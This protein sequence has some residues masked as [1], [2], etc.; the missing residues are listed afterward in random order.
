MDHPEC[1]TAAHLTLWHASAD[2]ASETAWG[3][4]LGS[5]QAEAAP[6]VGLIPLT[7]EQTVSASKD[8]C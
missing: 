2:K 6:A 3:L 8:S 1:E 5:G 4:S 7:C